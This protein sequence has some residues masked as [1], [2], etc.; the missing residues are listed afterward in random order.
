MNLPLIGFG[1]IFTKHFKTVINDV[2]GCLFVTY[3][4]IIPFSGAILMIYFGKL[5]SDFSTNALITSFSIFTGLLLNIILILYAIINR[6]DQKNNQNINQNEINETLLKQ[7]LKEKLLNHL[8]ANTIFALLL[9]TII[10]FILIFIVIKNNYNPTPFI[11]VISF[12]V[13]FILIHFGI[14]LL[15]IFRRLFI[16]LFDD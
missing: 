12:I 7:K 10:L 6:N 5:L 15:M 11:I 1:L 3:F 16:L 14:T 13:Y 8:Y 2:H 4:I 9:S